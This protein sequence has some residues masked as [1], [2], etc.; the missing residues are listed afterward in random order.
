MRAAL[1]MASLQSN[2]TGA[3]TAR[4]TA[5]LEQSSSASQGQIKADL[6]LLTIHFPACN[7]VNYVDASHGLDL[8]NAALE[9]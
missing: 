1:V 7:M 9:T 4:E 5:V 6:A 3:K 8:R 2:R